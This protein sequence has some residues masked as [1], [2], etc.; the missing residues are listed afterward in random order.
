MQE[1]DDSFI[2]LKIEPLMTL[3]TQSRSTES[4]P[5]EEGGSCPTHMIALCNGRIWK[6]ESFDSKGR[7]IKSA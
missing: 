4:I 3:I 1:Q 2:D 5:D 6:F 7:Y